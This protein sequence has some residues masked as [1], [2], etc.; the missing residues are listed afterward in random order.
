MDILDLPVLFKQAIELTNNGVSNNA[1][2]VYMNISNQRRHKL[3]INE[4]NSDKLVVTA[5]RKI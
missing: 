3:I 1:L 5:Y 4:I 2:T